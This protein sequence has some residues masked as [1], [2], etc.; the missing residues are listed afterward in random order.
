MDIR[1]YINCITTYRDLENMALSV[2][3]ET[4]A[5]LIDFCSID[6]IMLACKITSYS[7]FIEKPWTVKVVS[8]LQI[9]LLCL[10]CMTFVV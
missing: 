2:G 1:S 5:E 7:G 8:N 4:I 3:V 10:L 9:H 6:N